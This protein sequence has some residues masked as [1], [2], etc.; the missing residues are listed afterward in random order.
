[1]TP[2]FEEQ[3]QATRAGSGAWY[4]RAQQAVGGALGHDV[5]HALPFPTYIAR[6]QGAYKWD[7]D[8]HRYIDYHVG[9]GALLLGHA[10]PAIVEAVIKAAPLGT[11]FGNDHPLQVEWA[12][13]IQSLVPCGERVRF[14]NS[15]TE[16]D[17]LACRVARA[18]TGRPTIL[19]FEGHF[20]GWG[21]ELV[22]G[23]APPY[24]VPPS[25]GL[26]PGFR[27]GT[28]MT[29]ANDLDEVDRILRQRGDVAAVILEPSGGSWARLPLRPGFLAGLREVTRR[30]GTLLI[31]DEVIT[32]F[33]WAPGGAQERYGIT[34]D[35]STHAKI[36]G[37][38]VPGAAICGRAEV[39]R[40]FDITGDAFHDRFRRIAHQGTYNATPL[41]AAAGIACLNIVA[42]GEPTRR[43]DALADRLRAGLNGVLERRAVRG[44]VYGESSAFHIY[45][46]APGSKLAVS[47]PE[48][49]RWLDTV[50]LKSMDPTLVRALQNGFRVRG[51]DLLSYNGGMTSA[52]HEE[53]DIDE[54]VG[55]L[56]RPGRGA[57]HAKRAGAAVA[58]NGI[59]PTSP[60]RAGRC[61]PSTGLGRDG[62]RARLVPP[63]HGPRFPISRRSGGGLRPM[64][65][66]RGRSSCSARWPG[67][68]R[69]PG[70]IS[71][72]SLSR[73]RRGRSS[74]AS[75][76]SR[77]S[78]TC[79]RG[80]ISSS[81]RRRSS[82]AWRPRA[83]RSSSKPSRKVSCSMKRA[84]AE[85]ATLA[86]PGG[87]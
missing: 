48:D 42:T 39:M 34:P 25:I 64:F 38:G 6:A 18:H 68:R 86:D 61:A 1:M 23:F 37:G 69:T 13:R 5:R 26:T 22:T 57:P 40:V 85:A 59:S 71:T 16:S 77:A 63:W 52:A 72:S 10:H 31:F 70:A 2:S 62:R 36:I 46:E 8:G 49:Y 67:A 75:R 21:D 56:R 32:G 83:T 87:E 82:N 65:D 54:T 41:T 45:L 58:A 4:A 27:L 81:T 53:Q 7:V 43:A 80:S 15:G 76:T 30:H 29:P 44:L 17:M 20:H 9:N 78:T 35:L 50:T 60:G 3:I 79:G 24:D 19:R 11:H 51:I 14:T 66:G 73:T 28:V 12:E 74:S 33:R 84:K 47:R 55:G